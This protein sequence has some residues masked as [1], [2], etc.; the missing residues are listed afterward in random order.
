MREKVCK[1]GKRKKEEK[2]GR[3]FEKKLKKEEIRIQEKD[4]MSKMFSIV[5]FWLRSNVMNRRM[6]EKL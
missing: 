6:L 4:I 3:D 5:R 2:N 1:V